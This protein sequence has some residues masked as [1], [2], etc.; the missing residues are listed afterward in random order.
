MV[1]NKVFYVAL[2]DVSTENLEVLTGVQAASEEYEIED[3][4]KL[5][6]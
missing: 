4:L 5:R 1:S 6:N 2:M 3:E